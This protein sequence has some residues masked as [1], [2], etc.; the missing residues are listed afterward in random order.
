MQST[1][2]ICHSALV[3]FLSYLKLGVIHVFCVSYCGRLVSSIYVLNV[4]STNWG[5]KF[6]NL[7]LQKTILS[8]LPLYLTKHP[9]LVI[10]FQLLTQ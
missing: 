3:S 1:S 4:K 10:L 5:H 7:T 2:D 8:I 9:I 6:S